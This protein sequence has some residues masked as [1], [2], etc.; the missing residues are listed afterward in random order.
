MAVNGF[1]NGAIRRRGPRHPILSVRQKMSPS[2]YIVESAS[3]AISKRVWLLDPPSGDPDHIAVFLDGEFYVNR[4]N[5]PSIIHD[6]QCRGDIPRIACA[7]VSHVDGAARHRDLTCSSDYAD[8]V[9]GE[10]MQWMHQ[11]HPT[12]SAADHFVGGASL[13][14]LA[15]AFIALS[16]P[17]VFTRC[18]CHSGSFWWNDEWL[19]AQL[20]YMPNSQTRF[21]LSVGDQETATGVSHPPSGLRQEGS[22]IAACTRFAEALAARRNPVHH[23]IY[24]GGHDFGPWKDELPDAL[25]WLFSTEPNDGERA[26]AGNRR[27]AGA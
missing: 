20:Q 7:F 16:Y 12:V 11:R 14:G 15:A 13:S 24:S 9:A 6:L 8:F 21:W 2:E 5:G 19:T 25:R 26:D 18:L 10:L 3:G 1:R 4:M 17:Q 23:R 27:S 22:Q